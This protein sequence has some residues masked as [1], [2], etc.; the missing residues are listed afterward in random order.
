MLLNPAKY[1]GYC[2]TV[3]ELL[4]ENQQGG[5]KLQTKLN[6]KQESPY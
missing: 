3:L 1:Q 5:V 2:F 6:E 4:R